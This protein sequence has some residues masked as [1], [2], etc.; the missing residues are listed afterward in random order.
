MMHMSACIWHIS[1]FLGALRT[2]I[3]VLRQWIIELSVW[4]D[5]DVP[6][7]PSYSLALLTHP[8]QSPVYENSCQFSSISIQFNFNTIQFQLAVTPEHSI[9]QPVLSLFHFQR[10]CSNIIPTTTAQHSSEWKESRRG[11]TAHRR[12]CSQ[13]INVAVRLPT[14]AAKYVNTTLASVAPSRAGPPQT[15]PIIS[16][17]LC[18]EPRRSS[19]SNSLE[20]HSGEVLES[21]PPHPPFSFLCKHVHTLPSKW[22]SER[23][24]LNVNERGK[25]SSVSSAS[26]CLKCGAGEPWAL[27]GSPP[28]LFECWR[29]CWDP[30]TQ[31]F[32]RESVWKM[33]F[34]VSVNHFTKRDFFFQWL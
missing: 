31:R 3:F 32:T 9:L 17:A 12:G 1:L 4:N 6:L 8:K 13:L 16:F 34:H 5:S 18:L 29:W 33:F 11:G 30:Q 22:L 27:S 15:R 20:R 2:L 14:L 21:P 25:R 10:M 7:C 19:Y 28:L 23:R 26:A 24:N